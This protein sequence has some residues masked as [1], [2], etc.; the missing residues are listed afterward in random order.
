MHALPFAFAQW[1]D[2]LK[3]FGPG[4]KV[5]KFYGGIHGAAWAE[6]DTQHAP[7]GNP[8]GCLAPRTIMCMHIRD[9][10]GHDPSTAP[11]R[12]SPRPLA[13]ITDSAT[14]CAPLSAPAPFMA[15]PP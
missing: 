1:V 13:P 3:K 9:A 15:Y 4:L 5:C 7:R 6:A 14:S 8:S 2:E 10:H 12:G 11:H